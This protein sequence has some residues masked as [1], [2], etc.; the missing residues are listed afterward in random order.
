[1]RKSLITSIA[2]LFFSVGMLCSQTTVGPD[3][4]TV[5]VDLEDVLAGTVIGTGTANG[6][7]VSFQPFA[8]LGDPGS[9]VPGI[10]DFGFTINVTNPNTTTDF[11]TVYDSDRRLYYDNSAQT[12]SPTTTYADVATAD[13]GAVDP[14][15]VSGRDNNSVGSAGAGEDDDLE[16]DTGNGG[17]IANSEWETG[18]LATAVDI[19]GNTYTD[20]LATRLG[21]VLIIQEDGGGRNNTASSLFE[22]GYLQNVQGNSGSGTNRSPDDNAGGTITLDFETDLEALG[23]VWVDLDNS[24]VVSLIFSDFV[25][26]NGAAIAGTIEIDFNAFTDTNIFDQDATFGERSADSILVDTA[27]LNTAAANG[28][29]SNITLSGG[30]PSNPQIAGFEQVVFDLGGQS[31]AIAQL[32]FRTRLEVVPEASS[33]IPLVVLISIGLVVWWRQK[34]APKNTKA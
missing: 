9:A 5:I 2:T 25:D 10:I 1:M 4:R 12:G 14:F 30:L 34:I 15:D 3:N 16:F 31:G 24:S 20:G 8:D 33:V 26:A 28:G 6:N 23:F 19:N 22:R 7:N 21:N 13:G 32:A 27:L 18:N 29:N 11:A 17:N